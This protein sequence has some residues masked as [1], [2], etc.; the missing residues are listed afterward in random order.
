[1]SVLSGKTGIGKTTFACEYSLDLAEQGV[2]T[3]WGSFEISLPRLCRTLLHQYAGYV[4]LR[5]ELMPDFREPLGYLEPSRVAAWAASFRQEIPMLFLNMHGR[6]SEN[7]VFQALADAVKKH[8]V[9]H[10]I[11]DNLQFMMG[12]AGNRLEEKFQR[13]DRFVERLRGFATD[14]GS[15]LTVVVHPRKVDDGNLLTISSLYGG[16][17]ISQEADN[18]FLLQ[19]EVGTAVPK[20]YIQA[21]CHFIIFTF[22]LTSVI[23][24]NR[25]DGTV[26]KFDLHFNRERMSFKP[27]SRNLTMEAPF[28]DALR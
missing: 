19:E 15:H 22:Y 20:K 11:L 17:K 7:E 18:I 1:M 28:S 3:L 25:Y 5:I 8:S 14:T 6:P 4:R 21:S 9:E 24:K 12:A 27:V 26:G 16:G 10:V 2:K 13:Q 23:V